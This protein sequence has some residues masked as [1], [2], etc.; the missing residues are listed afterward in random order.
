MIVIKDYPNYSVDESG[1]VINNKTGRRLVQ[2]DKKGYKMVWLYNEHGRKCAFVH[3]LVAATFI[4]NPNGYSQINHKDENPANNSKENL[5]WCTPKYNCNY[6]H[7]IENIQKSLA[8]SDK[9][10]SGRKHSE[11]SKRK[12]SM[13]KRGKESPKKKPVIVD[14]KYEIP[15]LTECAAYLGISLTQVYN[16]IHGYRKMT[17]HTIQYKEVTECTNA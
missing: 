8:M 15:S 6:G 16:V 14:G 13:A 2:Y 12:I 7:H 3:R 1:V 11:E 5:E 10:W 4:P 17:G 9:S